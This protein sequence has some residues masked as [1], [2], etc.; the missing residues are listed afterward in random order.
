LQLEA[1]ATIDPDRL[2]DHLN[3][4]IQPTIPVSV[5]EEL[6]QEFESAARQR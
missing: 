6:C 2:D 5:Y 4:N 1:L 3:S